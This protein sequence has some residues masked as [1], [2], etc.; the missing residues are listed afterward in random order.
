VERERGNYPQAEPQRTAL[1][2]FIADEQGQRTGFTDQG[3]NGYRL[4][5][6]DGLNVVQ[7]FRDR[8]AISR[9]EP[10]DRWQSLVDEASRLWR[11]YIELLRPAS[12]SLISVRYINQFML[13]LDMKRFEDFLVSTPIIPKELPQLFA[14]FYSKVTIPDPDT[15]AVATI[16]HIFEGVKAEGVGKKH[17]LPII[18]DIDVHK[19]AEIGTEDD[20]VWKILSDLHDY[21]NSV[22]FSSLTDNCMELFQ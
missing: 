11:V 7:F 17:M 6:A 16:Q 14:D 3:I 20:L 4:R 13:P 10:Y 2:E 21:K 12:L 22:F 8:L 19:V 5:S 1:I 9:L 18:L 15:G